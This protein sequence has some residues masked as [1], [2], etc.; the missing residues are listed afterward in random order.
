MHHRMTWE[1]SVT[2]LIALMPVLYFGIAVI[3]NQKEH[4]ALKLLLLFAAMF[5][6]ILG[7]NLSLEIAI[8]NSG[9][10]D[11]QDTIQTIFKVGL[12]TIVLFSAYWILYYIYIVLMHF[13]QYGK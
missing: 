5:V 11:I 3:L 6:G 13:K 2:F 7:I 10:A 9:S 8:A 12:Y 1:T 4:I